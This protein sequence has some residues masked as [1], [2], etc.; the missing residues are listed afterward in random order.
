M[1]YIATVGNYDYIY[2]WNFYQDGSMEFQVQL[3][4]LLSTN[5][6]AIGSSPAGHGTTVFPQINA[7]Y[8]QHY[9]ALRLDAEIDGN[10]NS[11]SVSDAVS[12]G[13]SGSAANPYGQGFTTDKKLFKTA[14]Q[15]R[16]N[17]APEKSRVW[18]ISNSGSQN[19]YTKQPVAFKLAP[20]ATPPMFVQKESPIFPYAG[21]MEYNTWVTP[22][23]EDQLFPGGYYLNKSGLPEWVG[24]NENANIDNTDIVLW[25]TLGVTHI[26]R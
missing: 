7:Q 19:P 13:P 16:T 15:A 14:G 26:P 5:L 25:H 11:V 10:E 3:T 1:T 24:Q 2:T 17:V 9:F 20:S 21:W 8:H 4:G 22:Y 23:Q 18:L 6:M 12:T